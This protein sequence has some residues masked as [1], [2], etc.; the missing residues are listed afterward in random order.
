M[1]RFEGKVALVT[2]GGSGIGRAVA[3][4][5]A[6]EGATVIVAG[7]TAEPLIET[8]NMIK[9]SG[10]SSGYVL[11]DISEAGSVAELIDTIVTRHGGLHIAVNNAGVPGTPA[12]LADLNDQVWHAVVATNLTGTFLAMKYEIAHMRVRGGTIVNI[13]SNLGAHSRRP[14]L[15]AY[16][17]TKAAVSALTRNAA[18]EYI[19]YGVRINSVSPGPSD[20]SMSLRPSETSADRALRLKSTLPIGRVGSLEEITSAVLWLAAE[21]SSFVVGHDLVVDGGATA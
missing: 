1:T 6:A 4:G 14:G 7:R 16:V 2:G 10:G 19:G 15:G 13:S 9:D 17:A 12:P 3:R 20:T 18:L 11:A 21:E 8:V 5:L